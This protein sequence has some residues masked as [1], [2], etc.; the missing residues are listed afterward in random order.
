MPLARLPSR[1]LGER[2]NSL[3]RV[4]GLGETAE[5]SQ[6]LS[7]S[8]GRA[9]A[10][11]LLLACATATLAA[12][13]PDPAPSRTEIGLITGV[14]QTGGLQTFD[15]SLDLA[16]GLLLGVS[17]GW[18]V[19]PD[20]IV[21]LAWSRQDSEATGDL[22]SGPARFDVII[23]SVEFGGLWETRPG[24]FR[25][26]LGLSVGGTRVA[27]PDQD[28][29]EGWYFSGGI[30]GGVRYLLSEHTLLRAEGRA[31]GVL[32][33]DGGSLACAFPTGACRVGVSGSVLGAFSARLT[34]AATF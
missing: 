15:G 2:R 20:G 3:A 8:L 12:A 19:R 11:S 4:V 32:I 18:R 33:T 5:V 25:P 7:R 27:G 22:A 24:R 9:I 1:R 34:I 29:G 30:G 17:A 26:F 13:T 21:E 6:I 14:Q 31:S 23:D 10:C 16:G 28:F